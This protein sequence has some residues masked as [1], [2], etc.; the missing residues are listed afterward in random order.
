MKFLKTKN[1][2]INLDCVEQVVLDDARIKLLYKSGKKGIL[3]DFRK[4]PMGVP[5]KKEM[6]EAK[7]FFN[8]LCQGLGSPVG[9]IN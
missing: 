6:S 1:R 9:L 2:I 4:E 8:N 7:D 5:T 3:K